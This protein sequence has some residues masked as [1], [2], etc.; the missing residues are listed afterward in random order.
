MIS[1]T[2]LLRKYVL[3]VLKHWYVVATGLVLT[4][5]DLVERI[6]RT[7]WVF[8]QW[9]ILSAAA[10]IFAIAQFLAYRD[11]HLAHAGE[12]KALRDEKERETEKQEAE[13]AALQ[14]QIEKLKVKPYD[15]A[16]LELVEGKLRGL[17]DTARKVLLFLL[18]HG[19]T[20]SHSMDHELSYA[21]P[22]IDGAIANLSHRSL[23]IREV[24]PNLGGFN[25]SM[26]LWRVNEK[27]DQVLRD[28]L[29]DAPA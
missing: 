19:P 11:L 9:E 10:A 3:A 2:K 1:T 18:Q 14:H 17:D 16:Q 7:W 20:Q 23:I 6:L 25:T 12:L 5:V 13:K 26:T 29:F 4:V 28:V 24:T 8:K 21:S 15:K 22:A 27:F